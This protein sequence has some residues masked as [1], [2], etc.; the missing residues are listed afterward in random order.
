[1]AKTVSP[2]PSGPGH[3][4][5][6]DDVLGVGRG[7]TMPADDHGI[8]VI[9]VAAELAGVHPQTLRAYERKGLL[10]PARTEGGTR[11]Y[12]AAD[13]ERLR[14]IGELTGAGLNLQGVSRVL[15]LEEEL[16]RLRRK[17]SRVVEKA[18]GATT[19]ATHRLPPPDVIPL[20]QAALPWRRT[21]SHPDTSPLAGTTLARRSLDGSL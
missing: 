2:S 6:R 4:L 14:H 21:P 19:P 13:I 16:L 7:V 9:S 1:M 12:S 15:D 17:L 10:S 3:V 18:G 11:R 8:Y 20:S 5:H